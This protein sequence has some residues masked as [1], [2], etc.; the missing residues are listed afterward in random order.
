MNPVIDEHGNK[1]WYNEQ[2]HFHREDGPAI[3]MADGDKTWL[4][5]GQ[6]HRIDGPAVE[7][8]DGHKEWA[9]NG[10]L[11]RLDGPAVECENGDK[12][13]FIEGEQL[14]EEEFNNRMKEYRK[15]FHREADREIDFMESLSKELPSFID[16]SDKR[17]AEI[18]EERYGIPFHLTEK[19]LEHNSEDGITTHEAITNAYNKWKNT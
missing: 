15:N 17:I 7:S 14:T 19:A 18:V 13:W 12:F 2:G 10:Q 5:N 4:Q 8:S 3:E 16:N 1:F 6:H 11:H 9:V